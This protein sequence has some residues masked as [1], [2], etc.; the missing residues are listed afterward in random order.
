MNT[1]TVA[2][3]DD[4]RE[5]SF[6]VECGNYFEGLLFYIANFTQGYKKEDWFINADFSFKFFN[7]KDFELVCNWAKQHAEII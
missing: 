2:I 6:K 7:R 1:F 3:H 5:L 4:N